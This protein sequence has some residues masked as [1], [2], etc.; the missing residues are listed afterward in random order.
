[1][2][3]NTIYMIL[4]KWSSAYSGWDSEAAFYPSSLYI[5]TGDKTSWTGTSCSVRIWSRI[6][7]NN[8]RGHHFVLFCILWCYLLKRDTLMHCLSTMSVNTVSICITITLFFFWLLSKPTAQCPWLKPSS[9]WAVLQPHTF[10]C[11]TNLQV[12][13]KLSDS[14]KGSGCYV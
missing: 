3:W 4:C 6:S 9:S 8:L 7:L 10:S 5:E 14:L 12:C 13:A 11:H 2:Q 1:M